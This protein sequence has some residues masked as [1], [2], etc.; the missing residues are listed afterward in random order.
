MGHYTDRLPWE[1][2]ELLGV[3]HSAPHLPLAATG[4]VTI[5]PVGP[6][7]CRAGWGPGASLV[8]LWS[9]AGTAHRAEAQREES[10]GST[11]CPRA[12]AWAGPRPVHSPGPGACCPPVLPGA[13]RGGG[14]AQMLAWRRGA[15][16]HSPWQFTVVSDRGLGLSLWFPAGVTEKVGI[17]GG[18]LLARRPHPLVTCMAPPAQ[19]RPTGTHSPDSRGRWHEEVP[20]ALLQG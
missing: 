15:P 6:G 20:R 8:I 2:H 7:V 9:H 16:P 5:S 18:R 4:G 13:G 17:E 3:S 19:A 11:S 1:P 10:C 12:K 14:L